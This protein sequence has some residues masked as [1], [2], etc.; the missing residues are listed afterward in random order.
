MPPDSLPPIDP[1][2]HP[3]LACAAARLR[4]VVARIR[5]ENALLRAV[6]AME[7]CYRRREIREQMR[8][9]RL[10]ESPEAN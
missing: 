9:A 5:Y 8:A 3:G 10:V 7:E 2:G 1:S 6:G 4:Y